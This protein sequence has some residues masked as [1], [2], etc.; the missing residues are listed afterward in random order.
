M[1]TISDLIRSLSR[2]QVAQRE[3]EQCQQRAIGDVAYYSHSYVQDSQRATAEFE[4]ALNGYIDQRL[5]QKS[6]PIQTLSPFEPPAI[7]P[8]ALVA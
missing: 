3:L 1:I 6:G 7:R 8:A 5:A 2:C 4:Q